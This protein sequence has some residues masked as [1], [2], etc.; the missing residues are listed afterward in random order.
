M[1]NEKDFFEY[2][3]NGVFWDCDTS[4]LSLN[5]NKNFIIGRVLTR[6]L[7]RDINY[8][9][10]NFTTEEIKTALNKCP[11]CDGKI[12]NLGGWLKKEVNNK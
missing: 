10:Q 8:I 2:I 6:G 11:E 9:Y 7:E 4:E 1:V 12:Q 3:T 5:K